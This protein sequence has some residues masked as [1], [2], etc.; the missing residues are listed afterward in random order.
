MKVVNDTIY[1]CCYANNALVYL[2]DEDGLY[3]EY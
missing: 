3:R 2:E 1:G